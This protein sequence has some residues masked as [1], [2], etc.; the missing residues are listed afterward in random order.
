MFWALLYYVPAKGP[1]GSVPRPMA[2]WVMPKHWLREVIP[3]RLMTVG[4]LRA[5]KGARKSPIKPIRTSNVMKSE[6]TNIRN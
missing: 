2:A 4:D 5:E 6:V 3:N 1:P